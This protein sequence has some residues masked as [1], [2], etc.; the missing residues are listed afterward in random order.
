MRFLRYIRLAGTYGL[1]SPGSK[2][3]LREGLDYM[4]NGGAQPYNPG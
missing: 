3:V 4:V 1:V 2:A